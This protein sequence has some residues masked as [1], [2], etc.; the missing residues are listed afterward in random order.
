MQKAS[1][2]VFAEV[3]R[4]EIVALLKQKGSATVNEL[5]DFFSVSTATI[6]T[7]LTELE[8]QGLL[9]RSHGGALISGSD[10]TEL[11]SN[12]KRNMNLPAKMAIAREA[13]RFVHPG[14]AIALDT[15]TTAME[16]AKQLVTVQNLT[17]VTNDVEIALFLEQN[18][19]INVYLLGGTIRKYF[20]CTV[21]ESVTN[22][23]ND[24]HVNTLFL[25]TNG[26][27]ISRGLSTPGLDVANIKRK[28][29]E[30][31]G[32]VVLIADK[33]KFL[34]NSFIF[35]APLS[36]MDAII[37]DADIG[38]ELKESPETAHIEYIRINS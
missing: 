18:S 17:V 16:L 22:A 38:R 29:I 2:K 35:F 7:D 27:D 31:A 25:A 11:T 24:I 20:N 6:R 32:R 33:S 15:G 4:Q 13:M 37:T 34:N 26:I 36:K 19:D 30:I 21:G 12:E 10:V 1:N 28:M 8:V 3:R 23:L 9:K 14:D 5:S